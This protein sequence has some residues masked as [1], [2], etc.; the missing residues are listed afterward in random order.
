MIAWLHPVALAGLA[1]M[2]GPVVVHLLRRPRAPVV[3]FP[4]LRFVRPART[5][6]SRLTAIA[7]PWLLAL[8]M[9]IV[10]LAACALAGPVLMLPGRVDGWNRRVARA[11]VVDASDSMRLFGADRPAAEAAAAE[12]ASAFASVR[13][14]AADLADGVA[15][16]RSW[17]AQAPPA[18]RELVVISDLQ[19]GS[20][21][22]SDV[23]ALP[24]AAGI[25]VVRVG[26]PPATHRFEGLTLAGTGARQLIATTESRTAVGYAP[27]AA[28]AGGLHLIAPAGRSADADRIRRSVATAGTAA[29]SAEQP[30]AIAF[31]EASFEGAVEPIRAAWMRSVAA[32]LAED[33]DVRGA[34]E[35]VEPVT[36]RSGPAWVPVVRARGGGG[37]VAASASGATLVVHVA[38]DAGSFLA[39]AVVRAALDGRARAGSRVA[40]Q[41][42]LVT[43]PA[44]VAALAREPGPVGA[45]AVRNIERTDARWVWAGVL[46][47]LALEAVV[48]RRALAASQEAHAD[49]A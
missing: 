31:G 46:V 7:D 13:I 24:T 33:H 49:A 10:G 30:M 26:T 22:A 44:E 28:P 1:G 12:A 8:R 4:S 32:H 42:I 5:A 14:D 34:A 41:E 9:A 40:E 36:P 48:R 43:P 45:D 19:G 16:A 39:A 47:L 35:A 20:L 2:A 38:S 18:Q 21:S 25:R 3:A 6:A 23:A 11:I 27:G 37:L 17:L 15:R 29:P